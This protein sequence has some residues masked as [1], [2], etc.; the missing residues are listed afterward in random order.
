MIVE[1]IQRDARAQVQ[2]QR[3]TQRVVEIHTE[4]MGNAEAATGGCNGGG[5]PFG[6]VQALRN[7]RIA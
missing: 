5:Q 1:L 2:K 3:G 7:L 4:L 6:A